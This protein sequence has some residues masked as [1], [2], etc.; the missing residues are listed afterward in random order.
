MTEIT[1]SAENISIPASQSTSS[2]TIEQ[3]MDRLG[4]ELDAWCETNNVSIVI[5]AVGR[6]SRQAV[7]AIDWQPDTHTFIHAL[8]PKGQQQ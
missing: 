6:K 2:E 7:P 1:T 4:K 5:I 8:T 3:R